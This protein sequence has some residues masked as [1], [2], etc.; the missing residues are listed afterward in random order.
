MPYFLKGLGASGAGVDA[1][2]LAELPPEQAEAVRRA[3]ADGLAPNVSAGVAYV[4]DRPELITAVVHET[5]GSPTAYWV[6]GGSA[7]LFMGSMVYYLVKKRG[8]R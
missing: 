5:Q 6:L 7:V 8:S 1:A 4:L 3:V 2:I